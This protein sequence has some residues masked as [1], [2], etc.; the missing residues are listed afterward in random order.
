[1]K[2]FNGYVS[3]SMALQPIPAEHECTVIPF[4]DCMARAPYYHG[5]HARQPLFDWMHISLSTES[6][7]GVPFN[8][9]TT[10][11]AVLAVAVFMSTA[12]S[13]VFIGA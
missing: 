9:A 5:K 12:L 1:M 11:Q 6:L 2:K 7:M 8:R 4:E 3:G 10:K 13:F